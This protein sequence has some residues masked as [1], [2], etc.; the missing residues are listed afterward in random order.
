MR[1]HS[2]LRCS[3]AA[4][5]LLGALTAPSLLADSFAGFLPGNLVVSRSVYTGDA[6]TVTVGEKL[7]PNCPSTATCPTAGATDTG[8]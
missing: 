8:A 1:N 5:G 7:P 4:A 2:I 6:G 3:L